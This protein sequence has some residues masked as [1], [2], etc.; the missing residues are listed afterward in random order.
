MCPKYEPPAVGTIDPY[1]EVDGGTGDYTYDENTGAYSYT[2]GSGDYDQGYYSKSAGMHVINNRVYL[3]GVDITSQLPAGAVTETTFYDGRENK[4]VTTT[5][6]DIE[7]LKDSTVDLGDGN[8]VMP[9]PSNGL[10]YAYRTDASASTPN[11][12][13]L[14]NGSELPSKFTMV[15]PNPAYV[16]GDFNNTSKKGAAVVSDAMNLLSN[17]WNDSKN[18]GTLPYASDTTYNLAMIGGGYETEPGKYNGGLEN[19]PRFHES[20]S[21]K[22]C[23][24]KVSFV[25]IWDSRYAKGEWVYGGDNYQAPNRNWYFDEDFLDLANLPPFTP[26]VYSLR[27]IAWWRSENLPW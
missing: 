25:N 4:N 1:T 27:T 23:N 17:N 18:P 13:R 8:M 20:W 7:L 5:D 10:M 6:I 3:R 21:G 22:D 26:Q 2:P 24:L 9:W 12:I 15:T 14:K 16:W 11:G 19:Y